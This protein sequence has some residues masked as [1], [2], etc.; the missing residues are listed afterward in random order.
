MGIVVFGLP[1][2]VLLTLTVKY[3]DAK[4]DRIAAPV[5]PPRAIVEGEV[6]GKEDAWPHFDIP[7]SDIPAIEMPFAAKLSRLGRA[8]S[9]SLRYLAY[10]SLILAFVYG[11]ATSR[12]DY[13][14]MVKVKFPHE[15]LTKVNDN[16]V[17]FQLGEKNE[18]GLGNYILI[19]EGQGYGGPFVIGIRIMDDAR[20]HE[21]MLFDNKE[22]PAFLDRIKD[23]R[24]ADQFKGKRV[25]DD[26]IEGNRSI[27][28]E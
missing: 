16:P 10:I 6:S 3:V 28:E 11:Q 24:F 7:H 5:Q 22:T 20:I 4:L 9:G 23:A 13:E 14:T 8:L 27:Q 17:V 19:Q 15:K 12:K 25:S 21:A 1:G 2:I 26:F 18:K